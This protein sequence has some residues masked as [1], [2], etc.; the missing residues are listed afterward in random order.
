MLISLRA[1]RLSLFCESVPIKQC[2]LIWLITKRHHETVTEITIEVKS[3]TVEVICLLLAIG[4]L[5]YYFNLRS[6]RFLC[7]L[8]V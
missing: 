3:I 5:E 2:I 1:L 6:Q 7:A 4:L 8:C